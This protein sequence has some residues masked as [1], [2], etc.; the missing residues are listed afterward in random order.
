MYKIN[1]MATMTIALALVAA[2]PLQAENGN[3]EKC[4]INGPD[5]RSL[6]KAGMAD[7]AGGGNS[8]SGSNE[9]GDPNAWVYLPKGICEKIKGGC[10]A[11]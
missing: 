10:L 5:G 8:C 4:K 9:D 2:E 11:P 7:C 3:M 6:I 1:L